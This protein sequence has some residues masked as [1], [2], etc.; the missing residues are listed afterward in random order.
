MGGLDEETG[1][2][3]GLREDQLITNEEMDTIVREVRARPSSRVH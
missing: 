3:S 2:I 1:L